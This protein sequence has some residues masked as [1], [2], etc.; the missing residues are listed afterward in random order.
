MLQE[1]GE[2]RLNVAVTRAK[3]RVI[4]VT[5]FKA[6]ELDLERTNAEGVRLLHQYLQYIESGATSLGDQID[7]APIL[8][9]FEV[10]V[11]DTLAKQGL[12]LV[13]Q[14]G[15][16]GY[17]IDFAVRHPL[18]PEFVLALECDGATYHSSESARD[19]DRLRQD[20]LERLGWRF[21]RIWSSEWFYDRAKAVEKV[22]EAYEKAVKAADA[23]PLVAET[24]RVEHQRPEELKVD[25]F[26]ADAVAEQVKATFGSTTSRWATPRRKRDGRPNVKPGWPIDDYPQSQLVALAKWIMADESQLLTDDEV[27]TEMM[28]ELY[29]QRRG[30]KIVAALEAAIKH[31][32]SS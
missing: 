21:C 1:G 24:K 11:R 12:R 25:R 2:R 3:N 6:S 14:Y 18:R 23:P 32:K 16:S 26:E 22:L 7:D 30:A 19:R 13:P 29:F 15:S 31:A 17:R 9:P 4:L 27:L 10:D 5:S 8:N 20:Q 28:R